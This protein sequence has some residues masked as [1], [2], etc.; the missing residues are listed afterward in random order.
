VTPE[1]KNEFGE[2]IHESI[3]ITSIQSLDNF[4]LFEGY[5]KAFPGIHQG[6][7]SS[8]ALAIWLNEKND[9]NVVLVMDDQVGK[10]CINELIKFDGVRKIYPNIDKLKVTGSI[11]LL[12]NMVK[13]GKL[14]QHFVQGIIQDL[15][16]SDRWIPKDLVKSLSE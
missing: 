12:K 13:N 7:W 9:G 2:G 10:R 16:N 6:E 5:R 1:V 3:G 8:I 15:S 14:A 11:G 4:S